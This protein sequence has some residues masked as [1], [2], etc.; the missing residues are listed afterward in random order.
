MP[1]SP[2]R[3]RALCAAVLFASL[4]GACGDDRGRMEAQID[5]PG[6][7][8]TVPG[9]DLSAEAGKGMPGY[10]TGPSGGPVT[11]PEG[12][13]GPGGRMGS[14]GGG[15]P[16]SAKG[17]YKWAPG[18]TMASADMSAEKS[19]ETSAPI[20]KGEL[21]LAARTLL[22]GVGEEQGGYGLYSY[23]LF[24]NPP[25][26]AEK[27]RYLAIIEAYLLRISDIANVEDVVRQARINVTYLL[28]KQLPPD[29]LSASD[30]NWILDHYNYDRARQLLLMLPR[31]EGIGPYI[32][33]VRGPLGNSGVAREHYLKIDLS[34]TSPRIVSA[35]VDYFI[36]QSA[37]EEF[38]AEDPFTKIL[39]SLRDGLAQLAAGIDEGRKG[40]AFWKE[41]V[42]GFVDIINLA[43][44]KEPKKA[45]ADG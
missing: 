6:A 23:I 3:T 37:K 33:S 10:D 34:S 5:K 32:V 15:G 45:A 38:D 19:V 28:V 4:S 22:V 1:S 43:K 13:G 18:K 39:P 7:P 2:K 14:G 42:L 12:M 31:A 11:P 35:C 44:G 26:P 30:K 8:A 17:E 36:G 25:L 29:A 16:K 9:P 27:E 24:R 21:R 20:T 41:T 40:L